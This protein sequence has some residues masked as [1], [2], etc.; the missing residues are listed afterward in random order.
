VIELLSAQRDDS[1]LSSIASLLMILRGTTTTQS[2]M[3]MRQIMSRA[4]NALRRLCWQRLPKRT[5]SALMQLSSN[6]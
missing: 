6:V 1:S 2:T 4:N 5:V 3:A